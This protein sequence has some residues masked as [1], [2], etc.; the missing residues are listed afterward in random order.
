MQ[1]VHSVPYAGH[2]GYHKTLKKLQ[3]NFYWPDHTVDVQDFVLGCEICQ[4]EKSIHR[5]PAGLLQPLAAPG[6]KVGRC[7]L[8]LH[9]GFTGLRKK[10]ND[11]ILD[12]VDRATKMVH[13]VPNSA[14]HHSCRICTSLLGTHWKSCTESQ[15]QLSVTETLV[16]CP[17][18]GKNF[19][20]SSGAN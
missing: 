13:L 5:L 12:S 9:H 2:L 18:F 3:E 6:G 20:K 4:S 8:G 15:G 16:L 1:E 7:Q 14:D 17:S 19:G 11:G 10:K